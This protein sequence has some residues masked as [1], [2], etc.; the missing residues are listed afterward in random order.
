MLWL[1]GVGC[2]QHA[3]HLGM[4]E[5]FEDAMVA[6]GGMFPTP[7]TA[8]KTFGYAATVSRCYGCQGLGCLQH[9]KHLGML[10]LFQD[11]MVARGGMFTTCKTLGY[12]ATVSRCSWLGC[13]QHAKHLGMLQLFQDAMVA[14]GG[15]STAC[16]DI[17]VCCSYF[18]DA[19]VA[20]VGMF[21]ACKTFGYA[22][23]VSRC[24]GC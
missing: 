18:D 9:A 21:T 7:G 1:P 14:M 17:W 24:Y 10:Q 8:C 16:Q 6:R 11:A 4:L 20:R 2:L 3:K 15:M 13:L 22:A 19:M 12:A 5:L 23:T